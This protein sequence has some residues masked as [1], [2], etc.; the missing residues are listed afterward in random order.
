MKSPQS[1]FGVLALGVG[2]TW[3]VALRARCA[4]DVCTE[5]SG[6]DPSC[7]VELPMGW[8]GTLIGDVLVVE[9]VRRFQRET[10]RTVKPAGRVG[11][12]RGF[13]RETSRT[14]WL[15]VCVWKFQR[16]TSHTLI[17]SWRVTWMCMEV[18]EGDL[19][20]CW[21]VVGLHRGFNG[22]PLVLLGTPRLEFCKKMC[23]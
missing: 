12:V 20:C 21:G 9:Y 16:E 3:G 5:V 11:C 10:P 7:I 17:Q 14:S 4:G 15:F 6:G 18:S 2:W 1:S 8:N 22:R 13:Q 19:S 23:L